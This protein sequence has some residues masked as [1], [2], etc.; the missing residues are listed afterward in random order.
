LENKTTNYGNKRLNLVSS[1]CS[2]VVSNERIF[3]VDSARETFIR[4]YNHRGN[5][6]NEVKLDLNPEKITRALR[7]KVAGEVKEDMNE[8]RWKEFKKKLYFP[9]SAPGL[10]YFG[11]FDNMMVARTYRFKGDKAEFVF[12][13]MTGKELKRVYLYDSGRTSNGI[14][15][16]FHNGYFY[17]IKENYDAETWELFSEKLF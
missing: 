2:L 5:L 17:Y 15:F 6:L 14:P 7:E 9:D 11:I 10:N 13:D 16:C 8:E 3:I 12:F 1:H 4:S